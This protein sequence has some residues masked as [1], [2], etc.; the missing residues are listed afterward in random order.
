M[1]GIAALLRNN[2]NYRWLWFGQI[3][4]EVGDHFNTVAVLSLSLHLTGQGAAV[5]AVMIARLLPGL[6][7]APLAGLA[8]D[9]MNRRTVM[10]ASDLV[11]AVLAAALLFAVEYS[12]I[13]LLYLISGLLF[14]ASPFFTAGRSAVLPSITT[15][16]ELHTA[17]SV[18]QT[19]AWL[20]LS[21]GALIGGFATAGFGYSAAFVINGASFLFSA[22]C[23]WKLRGPESCFR[24]AGKHA[25]QH[26]L[27]DV[28]DGF[29]Y[30]RRTPLILGVTLGYIGWAGGGGAA[31]I[32]FT[33]LGEQVFRRGPAGM[34]IL[35]GMAGVGL[36]IGG[37]LGLYLGRRLSYGQYIHAVWIGYFLH[38]AA[39]VLF[40]LG[41]FIEACIWITVSRT[42]MGAN[43]VQ[44]RT[45]VLRIVPDALRGRVLTTMEAVLNATMLVSL[46]LASQAT[47]F[48]D[49][50]T[51]ATVAGVASTFS[52]V[53]W[54]WMAFTGRLRNPRGESE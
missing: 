20:T 15:A 41:S 1:A 40:S 42:A 51:I 14:F 28:A 18:T 38:G 10:L 45:M 53:P 30:I 36:V 33:L 2:R 29:R 8:L 35:W 31:Q 52:A 44:N 49:P 21:A 12:S 47:L 27:R 13:V 50:R 22:L 23:V 34:G 24:P 32:L 25:E 43:N 4:S 26:P 17:N 54:A 11:R 6:L 39:Y 5:G 16:E 37:F 48:Y 7:A 19:T 46:A 3:V 9:R